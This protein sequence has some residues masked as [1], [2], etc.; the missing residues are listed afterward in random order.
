[1][2]IFSAGFNC[3]VDG[4]TGNQ[5]VVMVRLG[6]KPHELPHPLLTFFLQWNFGNK[7]FICLVKYRKRVVYCSIVY[8]CSSKHNYA[9]CKNGNLHIAK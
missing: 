2:A 6:T 9:L 1:M 8:S 7:L 5:G 4:L 3:S